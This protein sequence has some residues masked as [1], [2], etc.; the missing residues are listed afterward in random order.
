LSGISGCE[1]LNGDA[2]GLVNILDL[3]LAAGNFGKS[4]PTP[5]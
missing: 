4:G 5:W 3:T 2:A 1:N